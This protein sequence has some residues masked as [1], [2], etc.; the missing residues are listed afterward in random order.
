[1]ETALSPIIQDHLAALI[2]LCRSHQ[3]DKLWA[4]GSV[5]REDF[6]PD[7][8]MDLLYEMDDENI[9]QQ[10]WYFAFWDFLDQLESLFGRKVDLVWYKGIKN[11][12]FLSEVDKTKILLYDRQGEEVPQ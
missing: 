7:S 9:P 3:V 2:A 5:L 12:Y 4:F 1:M 10:A 6:G 11:P 8:D